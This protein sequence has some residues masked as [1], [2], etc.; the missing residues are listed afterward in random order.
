MPAAPTK[1]PVY[2]L[3]LACL[4]VFTWSLVGF[5]GLAMDGADW[6]LLWL[7]TAMAGLLLSLYPRY[8]SWTL[9]A[10]LL[11]LPLWLHYHP[12]V[13]QRVWS[14]LVLSWSLVHDG[15]L[16]QVQTIDASAAWSLSALGGTF[17]SWLL[18]QCAIKRSRPWVPVT[19]GIVWLAIQWILG[20][21]AATVHLGWF[22][23]TG[24]TLMALSRAK[25]AP[26]H[27]GFEVSRPAQNSIQL[28]ASTIAVVALLVASSFLWPQMR[29][30]W[31]WGELGR[32][33]VQR[34]PALTQWSG[35]H[36]G[37]G[38][39]L[40]LLSGTWG[41]SSQLGGPLALSGQPVLSLHFAEEPNWPVYLR[42][43]VLTTYTGRGWD[44]PSIG[45]QAR[46]Y[47]AQQAL[48][49]IV[50]RGPRV[51]YRVRPLEQGIWYLPV[52][53]DAERLSLPVRID[54]HK[55]IV[56][57]EQIEAGQEYEVISRQPRLN[58]STLLALEDIRYD[59]DVFLPYLQ[60]PTMPEEVTSLVEQLIDDADHPY[61]RARLIE[62]YLRRHYPYRLEMPLV[63]ADADFV[64]HFLF[65]VQAGYCSYHATA[66]AVMLRVAGIPSRWVQGFTV[67]KPASVDYPLDVVVDADRAH[68]WVEAYFPGHGWTIFEPTPSISLP[69]RDSLPTADS[70][71]DAWWEDER[72]EQPGHLLNDIWDEDMGDEHVDW[73]APGQVQRPPLGPYLGL[74]LA[75]A[76]SIITFTVWGL[77][78]DLKADSQGIG[79]VYRR[80]LILLKWAGLPLK[81]GETP[82]EY[83]KR[84]EA[85]FPALK[86]SW[87]RL[88]HAYALA[89]YGRSEKT[90]P[91]AWSWSRFLAEMK[92]ELGLWHYVRTR[93]LTTWDLRFHQRGQRRESQRRSRLRRDQE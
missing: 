26:V 65:D 82:G 23:I 34:V 79:R 13:P 16:R 20:F 31:H 69:D 17:F 78:R 53:Y 75:I 33:V 11:S 22:L 66:M 50:N 3:A 62:D 57:Y 81:I 77:R 32:W 73:Q 40:D 59:R 93:V 67:S 88:S 90:E 2:V 39:T 43:A 45:S 1:W 9:L 24:F 72:W 28:G 63:P 29:P 42:E 14:T 87:D 84:V 60:L 68:A 12:A 47:Y 46:E 86:T 7:A 10:L 4:G 51:H 83:V 71:N 56:A 49:A 91:D 35:T 41:S 48:P 6:I 5:I 58:A 18:H 15:W 44:A 61:E 55:N 54:D 80:A 21:S 64:T 8:V 37:W 92:S 76:L 89:A 30:A 52:V 85:A 36:G 19:V 38:G 70:N 74:L 25:Q 27:T